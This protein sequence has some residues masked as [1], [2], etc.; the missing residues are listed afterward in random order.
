VEKCPALR[1][2]LKNEEFF[3]PTGGRP[4]GGDDDDEGVGSTACYKKLTVIGPMVEGSPVR[5]NEDVLANEVS[6]VASN[7]HELGRVRDLL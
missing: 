7:K 4:S 3:K 6:N 2:P 1:E 5:L